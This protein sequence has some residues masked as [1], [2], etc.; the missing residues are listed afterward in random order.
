MP[1]L[2]P[3]VQTPPLAVD[4]ATAAAALGVSESTLE[5]LVRA[6]EAPAPRR[7]SRGRVAWLWRDLVAFV[8][9][10]PVSELQPGP[11]RK[12]GQM[13]EA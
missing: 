12:V 2:Q 13:E 5:G 6:G 3:I 7:I 1:K 11:G 9:S 10:R 4:R 8:E